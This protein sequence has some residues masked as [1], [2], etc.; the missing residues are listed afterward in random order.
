MSLTV[1]SGYKQSEVGE[2]PEIWN[3]LTVQQLIDKG[4]IV[5]HLDG[6]HGELYPRS[7][8]FKNFGVP[9]IGANNFYSGQVDLQGCKFLSEE[10]ANFFK[11]GVAKDGDVLF[12]HNAT[13]GPVAKLKT[14]FQYVILSTTATYYRTNGSLL[15]NDYLMHYM[16]S[17]LFSSQYSA[18]MSQST[19]NQVPITAQRKLAVLIPP[20]EEQRSIALILSAVDDLI[21]S[22]DQLIAKK[23]D[24]QQAAMQQLLT[25]QRRLPGFSGEWSRHVLRELVSTPVTDGPHETPRFVE[26]GIPFLSVNNIANNR[27]DFRGLRF[28]SR[29]D[30]L[31]YSKKCRPQ[32]NDLLLGKAASVGKIALIETDVELN[33]WSPIALIRMSD[34]HDPRYFYYAFRSKEIGRQIEVLTN[35][36]SQGNI[37]MGDIEKLFFSVPNLAEQTAI[38]SLLADIDTELTILESRR[39]KARQLKQGMMQEL[40]TGRIRLA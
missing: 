15:N 39:E 23:R 33:I 11:K 28:I 36:S 3:C 26:N 7:H 32:R 16:R 8:E 10:R 20:I 21:S 34:V 24:I 30:H 5:G 1:R 13:V 4:A 38:A 29:E 37:G 40:L 17:K 25:G 9:Y 19:R 2:V 27:I 31:I 6:N 22:L 12:A 18:V 35:S 14:S